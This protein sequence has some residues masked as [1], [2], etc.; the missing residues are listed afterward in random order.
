MPRLG[1]KGQPAWVFSFV[2]IGLRGIA[3]AP[4]VHVAPWGASTLPF[5][6]GNRIS[7]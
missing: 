1:T 5:Q 3:L 7:S 2:P 6:V 4:T